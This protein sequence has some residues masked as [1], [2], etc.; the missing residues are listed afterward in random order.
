MMNTMSLKTFLYG[1]LIWVI[2]FAVA[3][4]FVAYQALDAWYA[5]AV[6]IVL[7][8]VLALSFV[9][10]MRTLTA[11]SALAIGIVWAVTGIA[12]DF[13]VTR[14]FDPNVFASVTSWI[15]YAALALAPAIGT[16][17]LSKTK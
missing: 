5:K 1:P 9:R 17:I 7:P 4:L 12:L 6:M 3:S 2:L 15:S 8:F 11:N 13:L 14:R 10:S 16:T